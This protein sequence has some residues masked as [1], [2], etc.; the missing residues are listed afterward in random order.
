MHDRIN[1]NRNIFSYNYKLRIWNLF[2]DDF[3]KSI[4]KNVSV[5][6]ADVALN[7]LSIGLG[8]VVVSQSVTRLSSSRIAW[9]LWKNQKD[10]KWLRFV[11]I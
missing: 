6:V 5:G 9:E 1:N 3:E 2:T 8:H 10:F 4:C 11:F 7:D